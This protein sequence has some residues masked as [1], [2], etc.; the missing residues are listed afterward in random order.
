MKLEEKFIKSLEGYLFQNFSDYDKKR[1]NS[2]LEEY[3]LGLKISVREKVV[4]KE[5]KVYEKVEVL[6][7]EIPLQQYKLA[8]THSVLLEEAN[9]FC[10]KHDITVEEFRNKRRKTKHDITALRKEFCAMIV[11]RFMVEMIALGNFLN[12]HR[13]SIYFYLYGSKYIS[14]AKRDLKLN[15]PIKTNAV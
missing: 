14:K 2:F 7:P 1:I 4:I 5:I 9:K 8:A 15:T 6:P 12:V 3:K 10:E 11:S 13:S